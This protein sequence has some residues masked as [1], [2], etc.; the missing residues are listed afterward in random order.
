MRYNPF[1]N[2]G[3]KVLA[4]AL[5]S[6]LWLTVAGQH[7]VERSLRVPLEFRN[8]PKSLEI[9]GNTPDTIDVRVRGSSAVLTRLQPGEIVAVLDVSG[10]RTGSRLFQVR[11]DEVRAPFGVEV[12]QVVPSTLSLELERS[13]RRRVPINASVDGQPAPGFVIGTKTVEPSSV[14][15][16]GPESRVRQITE[17]TTEPVSIKGARARIRD[18]VNVGV[19]DSAVHLALPQTAQ[20]TIDIW[21]APVERRVADVPIR[22]RNLPPGLSAQLSP[23]LTNVTVRGTKELVDGLRPDGIL[24]YVDLAGLGAGRYNLRVQVDQTERFGVDAID[25][26]LVTVTIR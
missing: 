14:E 23:N 16:V 13:A 19:I 8:I 1:R 12:T 24:A 10:A 20:V 4:I 15:V 6:L 7:I 2:L 21:P 9:V 22:W 25:P 3:L 17:A 11:P 18:T 5:A 26:T